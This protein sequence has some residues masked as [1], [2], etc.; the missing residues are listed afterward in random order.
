MGPHVSPLVTRSP[1]RREDVKQELTVVRA[2]RGGARALE[3]T[4]RLTEGPPGT[5]AFTAHREATCP[6]DPGREL[7]PRNPRGHEAHRATAPPSRTPGKAESAATKPPPTQSPG[8]ATAH[9]G[10]E[11]TQSVQKNLRGK[12]E[13][14]QRGIKHVPGEKRSFMDRRGI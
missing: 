1:R 14:D 6:A 12:Q 7:E 4:P 3:K 11:E 2:T 5:P 8:L 13:R 9:L 10:Y